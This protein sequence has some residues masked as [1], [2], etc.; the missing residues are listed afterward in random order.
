MNH[1]TITWIFSQNDISLK[2]GMEPYLSYFIETSQL[3]Q[4]EKNVQLINVI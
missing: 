3:L 1:I 4:T 2:Y